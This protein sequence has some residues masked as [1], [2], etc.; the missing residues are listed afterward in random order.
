MLSYKAKKKEE[1]KVDTRRKGRDNDE[2]AN[3]AKTRN[4]KNK[5]EVGKGSQANEFQAKRAT[6]SRPQR[7]IFAIF[8]PLTAES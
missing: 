7:G 6:K 3:E 1:E 2:R 4:V 5:S 8:G